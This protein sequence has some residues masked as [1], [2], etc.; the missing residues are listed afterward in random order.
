MYSYAYVLF[1]CA[2]SRFSTHT[3]LQEGSLGLPVDMS[4]T[5][6]MLSGRGGAGGGGAEN[7]VHVLPNITTDDSQDDEHKFELM[8]PKNV[9]EIGYEV[10]RLHS[11]HTY[12]YTHTSIQTHTIVIHN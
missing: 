3:S 10:G 1:Y 8:S 5:S 9:Q 11:T 7:D 4:V 2:Q 6:S 12:T